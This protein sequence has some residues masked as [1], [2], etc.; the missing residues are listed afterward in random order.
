[1]LLCHV[2]AIFKNKSEL[3]ADQSG[4]KHFI[5]SLQVSVALPV[6]TENPGL[7]EF[8]TAN[9]LHRPL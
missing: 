9:V 5:F 4:N 6:Y 1:M 2:M 7:V 8:V 3:G